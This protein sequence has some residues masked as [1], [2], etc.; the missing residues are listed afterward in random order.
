MDIPTIYNC[1]YGISNRRGMAG[2]GGLPDYSRLSGLLDPFHGDKKYVYKT[3]L[4]C[5][6][7]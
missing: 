5:I 6:I 3:I 7:M 4:K 2:P 1:Q